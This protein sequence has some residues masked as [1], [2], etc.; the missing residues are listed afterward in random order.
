LFLSRG[1]E[2]KGC[3]RGRGRDGLALVHVGVPQRQ[4]IEARVKV[5]LH[6]A[7]VLKKKG[8]ALQCGS[9]VEKIEVL[10]QN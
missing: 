4:R 3:G 5:V 2:R 10:K 9:R 7:E 6:H 1:R 8:A